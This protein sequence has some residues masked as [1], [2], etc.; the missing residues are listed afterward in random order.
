MLEIVSA[1]EIC[2]G[3][4]EIVS[5]RG[6]VKAFS[7]NCQGIVRALLRIVKAFLGQ[8]VVRDCQCKRDFFGG[9]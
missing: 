2:W 7:G 3:L 4:L 5:A 6:I 1:R 8:G 9:C